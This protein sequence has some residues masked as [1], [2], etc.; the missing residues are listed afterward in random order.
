MGEAGKVSSSQLL[1][2]LRDFGG[3]I[4]VHDLLATEATLA[5]SDRDNHGIIASTYNLVDVAQPV[6]VDVATDGAL[7][8]SDCFCDVHVFPSFLVRS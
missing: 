6:G 3:G 7:E 2:G 4:C 1:A 8:T 5:D